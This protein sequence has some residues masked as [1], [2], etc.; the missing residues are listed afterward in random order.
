[1]FLVSTAKLIGFDWTLHKAKRL[2]IVDPEWRDSDQEQAKKRVNRIGQRFP[3]T[4]YF[5]QS[6]QGSL[7]EEL[8]YDRA[9]P[10]ML[11]RAVLPSSSKI[12]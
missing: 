2:V 5:L 6:V 12:V 4:T 3:T 10:R 8:I 9:N 7:I 1:M 11:F